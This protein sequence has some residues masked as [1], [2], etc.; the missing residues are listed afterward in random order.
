MLPEVV[1]IPPPD[2]LLPP[3]V[4]PAEPTDEPAVEP[5]VEP[6]V[7]E[8]VPVVLPPGVL[9]AVCCVLKL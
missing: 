9:V 6:E 7:E 2:E 4:P 5:A 3:L 8:P 1:M